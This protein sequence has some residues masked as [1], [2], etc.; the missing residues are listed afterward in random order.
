MGEEDLIHISD[1]I[2]PVNTNISLMTGK[3]VPG[4]T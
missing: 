2:I 3:M 4:I 1:L